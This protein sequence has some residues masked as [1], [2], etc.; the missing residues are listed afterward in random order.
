M[1]YL[2]TI[3]PNIVVTWGKYLVAIAI[4][5]AA[6]VNLPKLVILNLYY[7]LFDPKTF[8]RICVP[9]FGVALILSTLATSIAVL[10]V[11]ELA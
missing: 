7:Q 9:I 1:E 3:D 4:I 8:I 2:E 5:Y 10:A 11:S 6:T